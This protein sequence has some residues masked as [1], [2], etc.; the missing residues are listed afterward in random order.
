MPMGQFVSYL[1]ARKL[2][3]KGCIYHFVKVK[4]SKSK[5]PTL[6]FV[7]VAIEFPKVFVKKLPKVHPKYEIDFGINLIPDT[8]PILIAT[9]KMSN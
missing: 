3:S 2:I 5:A 9:Y 6:E 1:K 4:D 8:L 7:L